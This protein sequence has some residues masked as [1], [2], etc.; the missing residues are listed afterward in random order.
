MTKLPIP[1]RESIVYEDKHVYVCL[2]LYPLAVGHTI[3]VWKNDIHD[4]RD[5]SCKQYEH[6]MHVVD[7]VREALLKVFKVKKVYL[8]YMDELE[9]VHWHL[10]PRYDQRG[11]DVFAHRPK[12]AKDFPSALKLREYIAKVRVK[13]DKDF[14]NNPVK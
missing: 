11:F 8:V 10:V 14:L 12:K 6:L 9:H 13:H 4:L 7:L 5:L 3:V 1:P 2:A